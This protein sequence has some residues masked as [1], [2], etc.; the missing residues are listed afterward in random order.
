MFTACCNISYRVHDG[1]LTGIG[2]PV[3]MSWEYRIFSALVQRYPL[4][5]LLPGHSNKAREAF[6]AARRE[7]LRQQS[8]VDNLCIVIDAI[9]QPLAALTPMIALLARQ[10]DRRFTLLIVA[11]KPLAFVGQP[12]VIAD[13]LCPQAIADFAQQKWPGQY[14]R[15]FL[16][17]PGESEPQPRQAITQLKRAILGDAVMPSLFQ[18]L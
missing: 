7:Q 16:L 3:D 12:V 1:N 5:A 10:Q 2:K 13:T 11:D 17:Q 4:A 14:Y 9:N 6:V 15:S 8:A 18:R